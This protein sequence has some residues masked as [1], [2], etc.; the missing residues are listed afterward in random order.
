MYATAPDTC[1]HA[2]DVPSMML[3]CNCLVSPKTSK[4]VEIGDQLA[5][6]STPGAIQFGYNNI[7]Q[8]E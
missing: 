1:G 6:I 4:I 2:V 7:K 5:I 8:K 3:N